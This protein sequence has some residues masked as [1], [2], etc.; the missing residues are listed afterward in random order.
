MRIELFGSEGMRSLEITAPTVT[1]PAT[2]AT[3]T[4]LS[5]ATLQEVIRLMPRRWLNMDE[6]VTQLSQVH[7]ITV[8]TVTVAEAIAHCE[9]EVKG[10]GTQ[11]E[12][13]RHDD[14]A[15]EQHRKA[16]FACAGEMRKRLAH[17]GVDWDMLWDWVRREYN[18]KSRTQ[19][20]APQWAGLSGELNA[21][22]REIVL[23]RSLVERIK[24][25]TA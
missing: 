23:F 6:L 7:G 1:P 8:N 22:R 2:Q 24:R 11:Q 14:K 25:E 21:A 13:R 16:S 9:V 10:I 3:P 5:P 20:S 12:I 17:E 19:M 15:C 18:V 4:A